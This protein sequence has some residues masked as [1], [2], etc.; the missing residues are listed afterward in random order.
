MLYEENENPPKR[1]R[2]LKTKTFEFDELDNEEQKMIQQALK[3]SQMQTARVKFDVPQAPVYHPTV[4]EFKN[5]L[6]YISSIRAEAERYGI[7]KI[8]PPPE[9]SPPCMIDFN[10][11][12]KFP[13][14]LQLVNILQEGQGFDSG[15]NFSIREYQ[16]MADLFYQLWVQKHHPQ[17]GMDA[18][19]LNMTGLLDS[20][21]STSEFGDSD[22]D[23][24]KK[25]GKAE[26]AGLFDLTAKQPSTL[27]AATVQR[28][29]KLAKD[30]WDMVEMGGGGTKMATV[31]Y[32]ND[33]DTTKYTSGFPL[34]GGGEKGKS[35]KNYD[36]REERPPTAEQVVAANAAAVAA[37][38]AKQKEV[39]ESDGSVVYEYKPMGVE[40]ADCPD[41][42]SADYY[43]RTGWNLVNIA[44]S[45]GS[46]LTHLQ[47]SINGINVPWLY[48]GMLFSSFCW[49]NEDN[50]L[51]SINY[52][53]FGESKQWY[54]V[55]GADAKNFEK[56]TKQFLMESFKDAP[57]LLHHMTTQISPSLLMSSKVPVY[58]LVQT[59]R[60][61]VVTF[62]KAFHA[63][64]SY[65]FNCGEAVNFATPDWLPEGT[66]ADQRYR[67]FRRS[68][69][70]S[71]QR[72]LLT[73]LYHN[74]QQDSSKQRT[75][76]FTDKAAYT[77][78]LKEIKKVLDEELS[79]RPWLIS[80]GVRDISHLIKLP[81]NNFLCIDESSSN[82]DDLRSCC[83]C[84]HI[85][86]LTAIACECDRNKVACVRHFM[87]T[88]KCSKEKRY[89][90]QWMSTVDMSSMSKKVERLL[91]E[92]SSSP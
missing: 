78:L 16:Q 33:L 92:L 90:L 50:Y 27:N 81:S 7:C 80:Q 51:Y 4:E 54:G 49:H 19:P 65:G 17:E 89:M 29:E 34:R 6:G 84:K 53:H 77:S 59:P 67:T 45:E 60:S 24:E 83:A 25:T 63:G 5:P 36:S 32:A 37:A 35:S 14:K 12:R 46:V 66:E 23:R 11:P 76:Q 72:L 20:S 40:P 70:F 82:Y 68:S 62:P 13:T 10:D 74:V 43:T 86:L 15:K 48:I 21:L 75:G 88:C 3:N 55:P 1:R 56:V 42:F 85:C 9:W 28:Y 61:F 52:S 41:M 87:S 26:E 47:T 69:V 71:H 73:L 64:F 30:Y 31:E 8:V 38:A 22:G 57:D 44:A 2:R 39:Q 58:Q 91:K 18:P 79:Q